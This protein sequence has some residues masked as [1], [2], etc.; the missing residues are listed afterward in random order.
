MTMT[1]E[2]VSTK[3]TATSPIGYYKLIINGLFF[4]HYAVIKTW[5]GEIAVA[6]CSDDGFVY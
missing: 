3:P 2:T 5:T 1:F 6:A 4:G